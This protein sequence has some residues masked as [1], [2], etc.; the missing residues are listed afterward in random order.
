MVPPFVYAKQVADL[1]LKEGLRCDAGEV[2]LV[3]VPWKPSA[4]V[5]WLSLAPPDRSHDRAPLF[6][7][8]VSWGVAGGLQ[9]A[10]EGLCV[11]TSGR[12]G[13]CTRGRQGPGGEQS[14]TIG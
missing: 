7:R 8:G 9:P 14:G 5:L 6:V 10:A 13:S 12:R 3:K 1:R 2:G 4:P 11:L